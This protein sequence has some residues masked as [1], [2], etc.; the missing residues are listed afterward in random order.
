MQVNALRKV[1]GNELV[2]TVPGHGYQFTAKVEGREVA[3]PLTPAPIADLQSHLPRVLPAMLGRDRDI[4][5]LGAMVDRHALVSVVGAGGIGKTLLV[6]HL[7]DRRRS[8]FRHGVCWVEL[9]GVTDGAAV[10]ATIAVA[11]GVHLGPGDSF[12]A[13]A[14]VIGPLNLLLALDNTEHLAEAVGRLAPL[15]MNAAPGLKL[16]VTSQARLGV[17]AERVQRLTTL[18]LPHADAGVEEALGTGA[19]ALFVDRAQAV[20]ARFELTP[21]NVAGVVEVCRTLDGLPLAIELAAARAPVL[22]VY[23][24]A[25]SM[26]DRLRVLTRNRNRTAPARQQTLRAT[27]EWSHSL[28]NESEQTVFRR[29]AVVRG[30]C[31]LEMAQQIAADTSDDGPF[32]AWAVLDALDVL[33]DRSLV[34]V[35]PG[36]E[37]ATSRYRLLESPRTFAL[38]Q[39]AAA[40][41]V[42]QTMQRLAEATAALFACVWEVHFSSVSGISRLRYSLASD[43]DNARAVIGWAHCPADLRL[44]IAAPLLRVLPYTAFAE[45]S[46]LSVACE[47]MAKTEASLQLRIFGELAA[48][49]TWLNSQR[50]RGLATAERALA[51]AR[52]HEALTG[53]GRYLCYA[54]GVVANA[55]AS[56]GSPESATKALAEMRSIE[57]AAGIQGSLWRADAEMK[58]AGLRG[59]HAERLRMQ[60]EK[61]ARMIDHEDGLIGMANL[62]DAE[63]ATGNA[64]AAAAAGRT[65][66]ARLESTRSEYQLAMARLNLCAALLTLDL[67]AEARPVAQAG[68]SQARRFSMQPGWSDYLALLSALQGRPAAAAKLCGYSSTVYAAIDAQREANEAAAFDRAYRIAADELSVAD[69]E[70]LMARGRS[71]R[72]E[73]IAEIA[74]ADHD[75]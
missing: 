44:M 20:D 37:A 30:S 73:D 74:F 13:L 71:L 39:L 8:S 72:D 22:G 49:V 48:A 1:L 24:L 59:D 11:L 2:G 4:S 38:E 35:L 34:T 68:W 16:V 14:T 56:T 17:E 5:V 70:R 7:L 18:D 75:A 46:A 54:L 53:D 27:L 55:M 9:A 61:V 69:L 36:D 42:E 60:R 26:A 33:V 43:F 41:E 62:I 63:L 47:T 21:A 15:L 28:L 66:V 50:Q 64:H 45:R 3:A 58:I 10:P 52:E 40:Q 12:A 67:D 57:D 65:L 6:Q 25:S 31:S 51:L 32:D 19:V 23:G 29:L